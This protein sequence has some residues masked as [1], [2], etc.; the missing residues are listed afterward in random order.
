MSEECAAAPTDDELPARG[1]DQVADDLLPMWA[2]EKLDLHYAVL[3]LLDERAY[4]REA[5]AR[6]PS[7]VAA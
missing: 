5:A 6:D 2:G 3:V 1:I 7:A 4:R